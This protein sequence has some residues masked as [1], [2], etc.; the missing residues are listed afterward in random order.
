MSQTHARTIVRDVQIRQSCVRFGRLDLVELRREKFLH[1]GAGYGIDRTGIIL[2]G[3]YYRVRY[4]YIARRPTS[5]YYGTIMEWYNGE[6]EEAGDRL[7]R[8]G[9][10]RERMERRTEEK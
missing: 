2:D 7:K 4:M 9:T 10:R 3:C 6:K 5:V 1:T 8:D